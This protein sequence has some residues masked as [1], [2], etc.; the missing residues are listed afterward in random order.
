METR[1]TPTPAFPFGPPNTDFMRPSPYS[2]V[3]R[4]G[5]A[6]LLRFRPA[7]G[8]PSGVPILLIP[9]L[10]NRWYVLDLRDGS[11]LVQALVAAGFD[12]WCLDWGAAEDEDRYLTWVDV[13]DR[14]HRAVRRVCRNTGHAKIGMLGYCMGA[15][16]TTIFT[17]LH[18]DRA[19]AVVNLA[20]PID[21]SEAGILGKL[22]EAAHFDVDAISDAGNV[23]PRQ[24][25]S[26]FTSMRPTSQIGKWIALMDRG[27]DPEFVRAFTALETW[28][29]DNIAFPAE[30]YRTYIDELYQRN[31]LI[32]GEMFVG[33]RRVDLGA[34]DCPVLVVVTERDTIC[35]PP[36]A[37]ALIDACGSQDTHVVRVPGGHVG[38][39]VGSRAPKVTYPAISDWFAQKLRA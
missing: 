22:T 10:I 16:L 7:S 4:D 5:T 38:G 37:L 6:R 3:H 8:E 9:S 24:M 32:Q 2:V 11:S 14:L 23:H 19:A 29:G 30:A 15:T 17:A 26:G 1:A 18:P 39:V 36:A 13:L 12:T 25:Q 35:P 20:G 33:G 34:I 21:F 28:A 31:L 27:Q